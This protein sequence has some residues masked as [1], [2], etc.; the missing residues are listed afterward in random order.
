MT[1]EM[2]TGPATAGEVPEKSMVM[3]SP[4]TRSSRAMGMGSSVMPSLSRKSSAA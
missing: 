3:L 1:A 4:S 2:F